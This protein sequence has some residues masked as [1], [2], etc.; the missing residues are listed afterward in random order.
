MIVSGVATD[1]TLQSSLFLPAP[2]EGEVSSRGESAQGSEASVTICTS[3][4]AEAKIFQ[5]AAWHDLYRYPNLLDSLESPVYS[6][7]CS[8]STDHQCV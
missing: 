6:Y 4:A 7:A 1:R 2:R 5:R 3:W 8:S